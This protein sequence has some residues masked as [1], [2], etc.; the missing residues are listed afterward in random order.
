[1]CITSGKKKKK[2][3]KRQR[4]NFPEVVGNQRENILQRSPRDGQEVAACGLE[5]KAEALSQWNA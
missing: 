5:V 4:Q 2:R 1:M 3:K